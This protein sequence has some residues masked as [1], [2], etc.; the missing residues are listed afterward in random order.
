MRGRG[1]RYAPV[2]VA[3]VALAAAPAANAATSSP[4]WTIDSFAKP[5]S[6]SAG[7]DQRCLA[8]PGFDQCDAYE[9]TATNAGSVAMG[10][11]NVTLTDTLPEGVTA[12]NASLESSTQG[13]NNL[14]GLC[15]VA[16]EK[17]TCEYIPAFFGVLGP[18]GKL[19]L[20]VDVTV[21]Q[22]D[23]SERPLVNQATVS[24]PGALQQSTSVTNAV[25]STQ[26]SFGPSGFD[27]RISGVDGARDSQAGDHPYELTTTIDLN[28][29]F[30]VPPEEVGS[31]IGDTSVE[32]LKEV[33]VDLPLG[34]AGSTLAAP[35]CTFAQLSSHIEH[36]VAGCPP[37]SVVG[38]ISSEP[39]GSTSV[40]GAI[41]NMVP[42]YGRAGEFA[43]VDSLNGPHVFYVSVV[44]T[45]KGY[46]LQAV[47]PDIPQIR[48]NH[49]VVTFYGDP[50][51]RDGTGNANI[52]FF[53]NPTA[54][55]NGPMVATIYMDS[56][57]HPGNYSADG[58]PDLQ[59]DPNWVKATSQSPAVT[60]CNALQFTPA[61]TVQ[62]TT[63]QADSPS[64]MQFDMRLP[65]SEEAGVKAAP[66]L[67]T[68]TV[69][70][71]AGLIVNPSSAGAL[72]SCSEAQIG[73]LGAGATDFTPDAPSCP[74]ASKIAS[75]QVTSPLLPG[76]LTGSVYLATQNAN[77]LGSLLAAYIVIDDPTTGVIVKIPGK[78]STDPATGQITGSFD[79]NPQLPFSDLKL[80]F[81]G[82]SRGELATPEGCGTFTTSTELSPWS[83]EG[84]ELPATPFDGFAISSG[85]TPGFAPS[86]TAGTSSPQAGG[87]S[88]F[89][90]SFSRQDSEQEISGLTVSLPPGLLAK[91]A[92]VAECSDA[93]VA[94]AAANPSAAAELASPS[95]P[96]ASQ[97]GT[98][99]AGAGAGE[100][101]FLSGKAYLT[102]PYKG[103]PYGL[104]VI[105][106]AAAGPFDLGN[107][108][109]R[110]Q[111]RIDPND[112][113][114]TAVSDPFPTIIDAKGADGV[115]DGFPIRLRRIDVTLDRPQFTL[116]PTSCTPMSINATLTST[117]GA[118]APESSRFQAANCATL[119]FKPSFSVSTAGHASKASGASLDVK[120]TSKGGPQPGGGEANI[121]SVKVSLPTQLPSRLTT[122]QKACLAAVF[123]ANPASCPKESNVGTA[124]AKTPILSGPLTG[125]AYLVSHGG[126]AFPD[127][128]IVLQGEG[129]KLL[130]DGQTDIKHGITT[131]TFNT[132]PD[133]PIS[134]F[135]LN[136]PT[137]PFSVLGAYVAGSNHYNFCG[138]NL[139]LPTT[140]TAQNGAVLTQT[141]KLGVT[142]CPPSVAITKTAVKGNSVAVTVKL[143]QQGTVKITGRGLKTTIKRGLKAGTHTITV[144]LTAVGRAAKRHRGKLKIQAAL[145]VSG[146]TGTATATL[147]A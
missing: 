102:G 103:A 60:G 131:S 110:S 118:T 147:K 54:C 18:D 146:R 65:Q 106:P 84:S 120:V 143:G 133:A 132:V 136:L 98:V 66:A 96:A 30:R 72:Q 52:P 140:I 94:A 49:I 109:V 35:R 9:V 7:H 116:N 48:L 115:T 27:F 25:S 75:V 11:G 78:L 57:Q 111:L 4:G 15:T 83:L 79:E 130:L 24:G 53:T 139:T 32:D 3:L 39:K 50:A 59:H 55:S 80:D 5:T 137:G 89:V 124:T 141:T 28:N 38:H 129:I 36:G 70:L 144:P 85:C 142:G 16:P 138:Q 33:V 135:E 61:L 26:P 107:V 14:G 58:T 51:E 123:E 69:T 56:W 88:P 19:T 10:E 81:F 8:S 114:A 86:F 105:V 20:V 126:A 64:G 23:A 97:V 45:A 41:Y 21:N 44:P 134:S 104:A 40:D 92:G 100:P 145:T 95:C 62:P 13:E 108:V 29:E 128:E 77:P 74:D 127:L 2:I 46:V 87:Y 119:P 122:L 121:R 22:A 71:P 34:F 12:Q 17:V 113:H 37:D 67:K 68:A 112:A 73:W 90:M 47:N 82:G 31:N 101:F 42:E 91:I 43:Y 125:P 1:H 76:T 117:S 6:F 99:Q 93:Q 63:Q